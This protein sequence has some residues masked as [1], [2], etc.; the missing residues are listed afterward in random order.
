MAEMTM[1]YIVICQQIVGGGNSGFTT[2]YGWDGK[3]FDTR[4]RAKKH[5]WKIRDSDDFNIGVLNH[6]RLISFDWMDKPLE[7]DLEEVS[8]AIYL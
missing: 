1:R 8:A 3:I 4:D 2:E 6:G 7:Y 5:G